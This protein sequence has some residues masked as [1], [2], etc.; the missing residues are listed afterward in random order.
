MK[1]CLADGT[2]FFGQPFGAA[3]QVRGEVVFH[4][5]MTGYVEALTDPSY[6]GQILVLTY[7]LIGN[8][9]VCTQMQ[10]SAQIQVQG[11]IVANYRPHRSHRQAEYTLGD[12]LIRAQVPALTGIDTRRLVQHLRSQGTQPG[13]LLFQHTELSQA[14]ATLPH[15]DMQMPPNWFGNRSERLGLL[16][17]PSVLLVDLGAKES[18]LRAVV[19]CGVQVIRQAVNE[20]FS[21]GLPDVDGF[22]LSSGPGD[23][24]SY[25]FLLPRLAP[26]VA[27]GIPLLGVC[28]GHQ[29]LCRFFGARTYKLPL[30]H[31]SLNQPVLDLFSGR[32]FMTSQNHGY[33]VDAASLPDVLLPWFTNLHDGSNEGVR[34]RE[35]P[36][37]S[38]QFHP[39]AHP[40]PNDT[41]FVLEDFI[42]Q[43]R[44]FY[45][46][47]TESVPRRTSQ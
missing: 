1:L 31:R 10:Q 20:D 21:A 37:F 25:D 7:P 23:P 45:A 40:G 9:G 26:V 32:S 29:I 42:H 36:Y 8:Y 41:R 14:W 30:G 44:F 16:G 39:E 13:V 11:L 47:K 24:C 43:V 19:A 22:I 6:R 33:A 12:W 46:G 15:T 4:T 5:G 35:R 2:C 38:V 34:H 18:L 3:R 17:H 27:R 28:L